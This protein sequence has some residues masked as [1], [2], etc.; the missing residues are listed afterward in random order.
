MTSTSVVKTAKVQVHQIQS[1]G[2]YRLLHEK[3]FFAFKEAL[4]YEKKMREHFAG[5][6]Y[7][8]DIVVETEEGV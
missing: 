4:A 3:V 7:V 2:V 5:L 8:F 6:P 1:P